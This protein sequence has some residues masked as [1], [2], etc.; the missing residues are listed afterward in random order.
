VELDSKS[1]ALAAAAFAA[2]LAAPAIAGAG[3]TPVPQ[4]P[5]EKCYGVAV[6]GKNDCQT[7][8]HACA[9][10]AKQDRDKASWIYVPAGT[11]TKIE[12]GSLKSA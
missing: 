9:G 3:P 2:A 7:V 10:E 6:A 11:C 5:V 1:L 12:G 8:T 4:Y